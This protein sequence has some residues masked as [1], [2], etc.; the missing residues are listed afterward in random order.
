MKTMFVK[1]MLLLVLSFGGG[2]AL[3]GCSTSRLVDVWKDP[4]FN[5]NSINKVVVIAAI[6]GKAKRRIWEDSFV[7]VLSNYGIE[8]VPSYKYYPNDIP[9]PE[10][11]H[12]LI[13]NKFDGV[14]LVRRLNTK[15]YK[16]Y[17]PG[18]YYAV[19]VGWVHYPFF[20]RYSFV[21]SYYHTPGY[22]VKS[23][24]FNF[25]V[26]LYEANDKGN[27]IWEGTGEVIDPGSQKDLIKELSNLV[28]P[29]MIN[30]SIAER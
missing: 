26:G 8:A 18:D 1:A 6:D 9:K 3:N 11:V 24:V 7:K 21:Y 2:I 25:N 13:D 27:L 10:D 29:N 12:N 16:R 28:I 23:R 5:F 14:V 4:Q 30:K 20:R 19:P 15:I 22:F 17:V